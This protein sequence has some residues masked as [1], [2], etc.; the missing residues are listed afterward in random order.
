MHNAHAPYSGCKVG[1]ALRLNDGRIVSG[2]NV[3][4]VAF[5]GFEAME[6]AVG[7]MIANSDWP[8]KH[9][10]PVITD[11]LFVFEKVTEDEDYYLPG[12]TGMNL[13]RLFGT[14][15][16]KLS[17]AREGKGVFAS[18]TCHDLI[19]RLPLYG[20]SKQRFLEQATGRYSAETN[21]PKKFLKDANLKKLFLTRLHAFNPMSDYSVGAMIETVD[22]EVFYGCNLE[23]GGNKALH[24]EA[25]AIAGMVTAKGPQTKLKK[26]TI[27]TAGNPGVP[28]GGCRQHINEFSTS[29]TVVEGM[30]LQGKKIK[31]RLKSLLPRSFGAADLES[32]KA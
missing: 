10:L 14:P 8:A 19:A 12:P 26:V 5:Y 23:F 11:A 27:L 32:V 4:N 30:N 17:F 25:V 20:I 22:G 15:D 29:R 18:R 2:S 13:L 21:P 24:A 9:A 3:E 16:T 28:C 7:S 31:K 6:T 1:V